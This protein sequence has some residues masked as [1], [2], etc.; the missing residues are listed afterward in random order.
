M[1]FEW[2]QNLSFLGINLVLRSSMLPQDH[3][4][5]V[6]NLQSFIKVTISCANDQKLITEEDFFT[7]IFSLLIFPFIIKTY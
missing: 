1:C 6:P 7:V 5:L 4:W 2:G 3:Y